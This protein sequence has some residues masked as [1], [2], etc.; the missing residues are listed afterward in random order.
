MK[1]RALAA[2]AIVCLAGC[3]AEERAATRIARANELVA[4]GKFEE[5][6]FELR[7]ALKAEPKN[8]DVNYQLA[9]LMHRRERLP[10]AVFFYEEALRLDPRH[11]DAAL[12]LAF[13]MLGDDVDYSQRL[14]DGVIERDPKNALAWVRR[15]DIA[16][17]RG[18]ADAALSAALTAAELA[19]QSARTQI[20][21]GLVHRARIRKHKL[22][23]EPV[24]DSVYEDALAAFE[25]ASEG[26]D[27]SRDHQSVALAWVERANTLASW[28]ARAG[29]AGAAYREA[30]EAARKL[31]GSYDAALDAALT[32]ARRTQDAELQRWALES[33]VEV[34]PERLELWR[35][36]ARATEEPGASSSPTL[37]RMISR[38]AKDARAHSAYARDLAARGRAKDA[39]AHL[40]AVAPRLDEP[41]VARFAQVEIASAAGDVEAAKA[42]AARLAK[43]HAGSF[44]DR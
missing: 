19:P 24:P 31:G 33:G 1:R 32:H 10:D 35:S 23:K 6:Q 2:L 12:T 9:R 41:A 5:A 21:A 11:A 30:F 16:L 37:E 7:N 14:V 22:L 29:E 43:E 25:R 13:L 44:E 26:E 36:L 8:A 42:A 38:R 27:D 4:A 28:P 15:S 17:A 39:L 3:G 40:D 34:Y 18:D 20:Q